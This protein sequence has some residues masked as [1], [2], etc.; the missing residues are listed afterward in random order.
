MKY[1]HREKSKVSFDDRCEK[2]GQKPYIFWFTGLSGSGKSTIADEFEK[3]LFDQGRVV[4]RLDADDVRKRL[5]EDLGFTME[6][7]AENIRRV[8]E[9]ARIL[10]DAGVIVLATFISPTIE[11]RKN[12]R[13]KARDNMFLEIYVKASVDTCIERDPKGFYK[14]A[15]SGEIKNFTGI[16]SS[17]EAPKKAE[18]TLD[19]DKNN[20][21]TCVES[22]LYLARST[23]VIKE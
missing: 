18:L 15:L 7:R 16:E 17:Y 22:L 2:Y 10:Q 6:N 19:T 20:V 14:K 21:K 4:F 12:A 13:E 9:V 3:V 8:A 23:G 1:L 5:N 11:M